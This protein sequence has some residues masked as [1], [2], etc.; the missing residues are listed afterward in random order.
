MYVLCLLF[1]NVYNTTCMYKFGLITK[2]NNV[3]CIYF[4][5]FYNIV[6]NNISACSIQHSYILN[7][8]IAYSIQ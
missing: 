4:N 2:L 3:L 1:S 7:S 5:Y 6:L 8:I